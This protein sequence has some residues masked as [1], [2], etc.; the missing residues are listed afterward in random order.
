MSEILRAFR[1]NAVHV[2]AA[3]EARTEID[4]A[5]RS[6]ASPPGQRD[7]FKRLAIPV[8]RALNGRDRASFVEAA[9]G[10][11]PFREVA[12]SCDAA[13]A[14]WRQIDLDL[15]APIALGG[16][17]TT[18]REVATAWLEAAAFF[19]ERDPD[20][21][22]DAFLDRWGTAGEAIGLQYAEQ[23]ARAILELDRAAAVVL[24]EPEILPPPVKSFEPARETR[25]RW[26]QRRKK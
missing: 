2:R 22:Y 12:G 18:R 24:E 5:G 9:A 26:W 6:D 21:A 7:G 19:D 8:R 1:R 11:R 10:V 14:A 23:V 16:A 25:T 3:L 4:R 20:H 17:R 15:N 13:E